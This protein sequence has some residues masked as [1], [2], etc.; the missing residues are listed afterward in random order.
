MSY[1]VPEWE[2]EFKELMDKQKNAQLAIDK[3]LEQPI[4]STGRIGMTITEG[5][6]AGGDFRKTLAQASRKG[7]TKVELATNEQAMGYGVEGYG[8]L[9]RQELRELQFATGVEVNS[10]HVPTYVEG[11]SGIDPERGKISE[12]RINLF[13]NKVDHV[14]K[15]ASDIMPKKQESKSDGVAIVV[16]VAEVPG[17]PRISALK[18]V[19]EE[20]EKKYGSF[21]VTSEKPYYVVDVEKGEI[22]GISEKTTIPIA[23]ESFEIKGNEIRFKQ[24]WENGNIK[25]DL[26]SFEDFKKAGELLKNCKELK[27]IE[28]IKDEKLKAIAA[29]IASNA[30]EMKNKGVIKDVNE[31]YDKPHLSLVLLSME[32]Q[33]KEAESRKIEMMKE[34]EQIKKSIIAL[35]QFK[36]ELKKREDI[37]QNNKELPE[38]LKR[39]LLTHVDMLHVAGFNVPV[40]ELKKVDAV[41]KYIQTLQVEA[42]RRYEAMI[43]YEEQLKEIEARKERIKALE[44]VAINKSIETLAKMGLKALEYTQKNNLPKPI[45][46]APENW[47]AGRGFGTHP[48][49]ILYLI[50]EARKKMVEMLTSPE[51]EENG[52]KIKNPFYV[53]DVNKAK[54]LAEKHIK[55]TLDTEHMALWKN[56][57]KANNPD[58]KDELFLEWFKEKVQKLIDEKVIGN[59]HLVDSLGGH[60]QLPPGE[61]ELPLKEI[62]KKLV[63]SGYK[64]PINS[65]GWSDPNEQLFAAW[66]NIANA[67]YVRGNSGVSWSDVNWD[68]VYHKYRVGEY[69]HNLYLIPSEDWK[70]WS[71][72]PLN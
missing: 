23:L 41:E 64:G 17:Q 30:I 63:E 66:R 43:S 68:N 20:E 36:E 56:Y 51:I 13:M 60:S 40:D 7:T 48:D 29:K 21:V 38:P 34:F 26:A 37:I 54:E 45:Y 57:F 18:N 32:K 16:H 28:K 12:D 24:P 49:E 25:V 8:N 11:L 14:M 52:K 1:Y 10:V 3:K 19:Y 5:P 4:I 22:S 50:K 70:F 31:L 42:K 39:Y 71:G 33:E 2:K 67:V 58:K 9:K 53:K 27:E 6:N 15:F 62:V 65:E 44:D 59:V 69:G 47:E 61:G 55:M 72:L 35:E 46:I